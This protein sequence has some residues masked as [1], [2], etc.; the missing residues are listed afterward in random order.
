MTVMQRALILS[1][2]SCN[3]IGVRVFHTDADDFIQ[4]IA[5]LTPQTPAAAVVCHDHPD[6]HLR[7]PQWFRDS[8]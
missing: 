1:Q 5:P 3:P 7:K 2:T 8:I 6:T 4:S